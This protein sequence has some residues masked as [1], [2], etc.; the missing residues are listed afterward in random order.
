M[1]L[2]DRIKEREK[3]AQKAAQPEAVVV[4]DVK[5]QV[6]KGFYE[7]FHGKAP[8]SNKQIQTTIQKFVKQLCPPSLSPSV[9]NKIYDELM[10]E[11][12]GLGP[13]EPLF[14]ED[15]VE[16]IVVKDADHIFVKK[17]E[18]WDIT[19]HHF[20]DADQLQHVAEQIFASLEQALVRGDFAS[21]M[22][23]G[24]LRFLPLTLPFSFDAWS[25]S[26][27]IGRATAAFLQSEAVA[28]PPEEFEQFMNLQN[29]TTFNVGLYLLFRA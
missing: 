19:E 21:K 5:E 25:Q 18:D 23:T 10:D 27:K 29:T 4:K 7:E 13:L 8:E 9:K 26:G 2:F 20:R 6:L 11:L 1:S 15:G 28:P 24:T 3:E 14:R 16:H 17:G 22:S 12:L